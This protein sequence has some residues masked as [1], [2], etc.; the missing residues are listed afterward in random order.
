MA[1]DVLA[2]GPWR[3]V[4]F[5][6]S[7]EST[8]DRITATTVSG[9]TDKIT[10]PGSTLQALINQSSDYSPLPSPLIF[11]LTN[12]ANGKF[13]HVGVKEFS[14]DE[15]T[16]N[17]PMPVARNLVLEEGFPVEAKLVDLPKGTALTLKPLEDYGN[18]IS[19]WK[20]LLEAKL[21]AVFT[22][23]T[24][25]DVLV[26]SHP[27]ESE[28]L[29]RF[30][31]HDLKP[32]NAVCIVDTDLDLDI[33]TADESI[34]QKR[35]LTPQET[36]NIEPEN[37]IRIA[38]LD[39][40]TNAKFKLTVSK[41]TAVNIS[42][43]DVKLA[44]ADPASLV[45]YVGTSELA[46]SHE[47]FLWSSV[48]TNRSVEIAVDDP[49]LE[50]ELYIVVRSQV[51]PAS[52][53][54]NIWEGDN[55]VVQPVKNASEDALVCPNCKNVIPK[56]TFQLHRNFCERNNLLCPKGCGKVFSR[57]EGITKTHW[58]CEECDQ[59]GD[60]EYAF[61]VHRAAAH[62]KSSC[63]CGQ[64]FGNFIA[65]AQ[66]RATTCPAKLHMCRFCHLCL[67]QEEATAADIL[68]GLTAHESYCG[69]R[70]TD[71]A[72][73]RKAVR[74]R[75]LESHMNYHNLD[76]LARRA[77]SVCSN[78]NCV[79]PVTSSG[80]DFGLCG[81]CF[82]PLHSTALDTTGTKLRSRVERRYVIQISRGCGKSWCMNQYCATGN[83][84]PGRTMAQI[85]SED[86]TTLMDCANRR[87]F[88]FCV[89]ETATKR[90]MFVDF[91]SA[92]G[93]YDTPWCA[94]AIDECKGNESEARRWLEVHGKKKQEEML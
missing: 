4:A 54:L 74:L 38:D 29:F 72:T 10:L 5:L 19:D 13:T 1:T 73:C 85:M 48:D 69:N 46:T 45:A 43:D 44:D 12:P 28:K 64:S 86:I 40:S 2:Q 60:S 58:H 83:P 81:V 20:A 62:T 93:E 77:A 90:K 17:I 63:N 57:R 6:P 47:S 9:N 51:A 80:Q 21:H 26:I 11:R 16:A 82:G 31:I 92:D 65:V 55:D 24:K 8:P 75:E 49:F 89:D 71:C 84:R 39:I 41:K 15:G 25:G 36:V 78:A 61:T 18:V 34:P 91:E 14:A 76:R 30:V 27:F 32:S 88:W 7:R 23:L 50:S 3:L 79:R 94:Q 70:T 66:H 33:L 42:L 35:N 37:P 53:T 87:E 59:F 67:P 52:F 22:A 68:Q 56:Q